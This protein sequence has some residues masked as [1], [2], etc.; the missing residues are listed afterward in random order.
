[1]CRLLCSK[2]MSDWEDHFA[3]KYPIVGQLVNEREPR[4]LS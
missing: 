4:A 1:M 2:N 3:G